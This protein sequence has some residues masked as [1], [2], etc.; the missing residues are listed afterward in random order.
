MM[1][2]GAG[3]DDIETR[4]IIP[5][6][7]YRGAFLDRRGQVWDR[8]KPYLSITDPEAIRETPL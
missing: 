6:T 5:L 1:V 8:G 2:R 3:S 7:A 4:D